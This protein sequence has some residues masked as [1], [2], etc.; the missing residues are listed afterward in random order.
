MRRLR[1]SIALVALGCAIG[2][3]SGGGGTFAAFSKTTSNAGNGVTAKR[4]FPG[5][6][7]SSGWVVSDAADGSAANV[8]DP[9]STA[10]DTLLKSTGNF[11]NAFAANRW[12]Q[13]DMMGSLPASVPVSGVTFDFNFTP[14]AGGNT[15]C[16]YF[17]VIRTSTGTILGTHGSSGTPVAC[18]TGTTPTT[19]S[20]ALTEITSAD[21]LNDLTI[22][23]YGRESGSRP[24]KID[25][26]R[27]SGTYTYGG[28]FALFQK[29]TT[30]SAT[31]TA[32]APVPWTLAT[33]EATF[34]QTGGNWQNAF[35]AARLIQI[36]FPAF[37]T[38]GVTVTSSTFTHVYKS[39]G[40][41]K[42]SCFYYEAWSGGVLI[43]TYGSSGSPFC[44]DTLGNWKTDTIDMS[45]DVNTA[46][47][48]NGLVIKM[49]GRDSGS[50][51]SN[52]DKIV[53]SANYYLD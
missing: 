11:S 35:N 34:L 23:V 51:K 33:Q 26:A 31:G 16:F 41:G 6:R 7:T 53:L 46:A 4:I 40:A 48:L 12:F 28:S 10:G 22:K 39:N 43:Q 47:E 8:S 38:S 17:E 27:V 14:N 15:G 2:L 18:G 42:S 49:Y 21:A 29:S 24:L 3:A 37:V 5:V 45:A 19:T 30:D 1:H 44:S 50:T 52:H 32:G 13:L 9:M 36:T 25:L 20:T